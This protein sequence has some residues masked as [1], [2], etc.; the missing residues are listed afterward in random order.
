MSNQTTTQ[1]LSKNNKRDYYLRNKE[2]LAAAAKERYINNRESR[3]KYGKEYYSKNRD[4]QIKSS[5]DCYKRNKERRLDLAKKWYQQNRDEQ[6]AA[7]I[8]NHER[9]RDKRLAQMKIYCA[10][11]KKSGRQRAKHNEYYSRNK[12]RIKEYTQNHRLVNKEEI[13][14]RFKYRRTNDLH[15]KMVG[16]LRC[17]L[18]AALRKQKTN[19]D[20]KTLELLGC[21]IEDFVQYIERQWLPGM[22]WENH[23]SNGWHIDHIKPCNTFDLT[24]IEEQ[25]KCFHYTNLRPLWSF[26]N[27]SR[28]HDGSDV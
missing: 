9:N 7:A 2:K 14:K 23:T 25:R 20:I 3:L 21:T 11:Y 26:D 22:N 17:R 27:R 24:N 16:I 18:F 19:K 10:E 15:F 6:R 13:S 1:E 12:E 28:P 4:K 5:T 8:A